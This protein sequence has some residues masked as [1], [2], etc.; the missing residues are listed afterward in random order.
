MPGRRDD[1][2]K[3]PWEKKLEKRKKDQMAIEAI[4]K[5]FGC[6]KE[7]ASEAWERMIDIIIEEE[8][9]RRQAR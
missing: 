8:R 4:E 9:Q 1:P 6:S 5:L 7:K 2:E 3:E